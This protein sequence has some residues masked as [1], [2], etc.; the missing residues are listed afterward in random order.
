VGTFNNWTNPDENYAMAAEG[1]IYT[2]TLTLGADSYK[3][4]VT[5]GTWDDG[6]NWGYSA[7]SEVPAGVTNDADGNI[8]FTLA[9]AGD[10]VVTFNGTN[11]TIAGNFQV[12]T[13][14]AVVTYVLMG[15]AGDWTTGIAMTQNP[16]NANEYVL[17]GQEIAEGD[18]VKVVTLTDG[19][20]T[21]WCGNVDEYSV[22]H[23][24]DDMGNIVLAPGKYDFYYK[25]DTD[26]IYIGGTPS[27]EPVEPNPATE[28][29]LEDA[30]KE[31]YS[32]TGRAI[33]Y[34]YN[35]TFGDLSVIVQNYAGYGTYAEGVSA[36]INEVTCTGSAVFENNGEKDLFVATLTNET[37]A[38]VY[39][40]KA[41]IPVPK[42][43]TLTATD[44]V[45]VKVVQSW[46][47]IITVNGLEV[48]G[49][50]MS[51]EIYCM[52]EGNEATLAD[53]YQGLVEV[54][55]A[56]D[57]SITITGTL[58]NPVGDAYVLNINATPKASET[59]N[60]TLTN[61]NIETSKWDTYHKFTAMDDDYEVEITL[62]EAMDLGYGEYESDY[63]EAYINSEYATL[64]E[65]TVAKYYEDETTGLAVVE[66]SLIVGVDTYNVTMTGTPWVNPEDIIPTDTV[67][68]VIT[69][70]RIELVYNMFWA[71]EGKAAN[72]EIEVNIFTNDIAT[73][74]T[75]AELGEA[76]ITTENVEM[77]IL[78]GNLNIVE[79]NEDKV[80]YISVLCSDHKWYNITVT[81]AAAVPAN[82]GTGFDNINTTVAPVKMIKNGQLIIRNNGVEYN[83]Q[84]AQL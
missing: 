42:T 73:S 66:M 29:V 58:N 1:D 39:V 80:A 49:E 32:A 46:A 70:A 74:A 45:Y 54:V 41:E 31:F 14:P 19:T 53:E 4:K 23:S 10:V 30:Y 13:E 63:V 72:E 15:V 62:Y 20:A 26:I 43:Y 64:A 7:L 50:K 25:V 57:N 8:V 55:Y 22:A 83:A 12:S 3:L 11:V 59:F 17:L 71:I 47:E 84:G 16:D 76:S 79:I 37:T 36:D 51:L 68:A 33:F 82:P 52:S 48:D 60:V 18:A 21:A 65:G 5:N 81:T 6:G 40:I 75:A 2:K 34:G 9:E 56:D 38:E 69:N 27:E 28:I 61:M 24:A 35:A 77:A 67:N 78:R 44:A